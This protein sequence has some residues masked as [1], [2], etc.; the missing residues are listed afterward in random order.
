M[1]I[2]VGIIGIM[3]GLLV[4]MQ[5]CTIMVGSDIAGDSVTS[6]SGAV[7]ILIGFLYFVGGAF[8]FGLPTVSLVMFI[9]AAVAGFAA[10]S[11]GV[12]A[13]LQIWAYGALILAVMSFFALRKARKTSGDRTPG[14]GS[15]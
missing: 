3:L 15:R 4:I 6:E 11:Q 10:A 2:A 9:I 12:F 5:S 1:R 8:A 13:D 7:G 14:E